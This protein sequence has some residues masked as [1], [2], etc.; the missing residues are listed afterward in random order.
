[1]NL[2]PPAFASTLAVIIFTFVFAF[3]SAA[4]AA[5]QEILLWPNGTPAPVVPN[6]PPE[7]TEIGADGLSR[8]WHVSRPRLWIHHPPHGTVPSGTGI[9]VVPG[10]GFGRLADEHEGA[11]ACT[12]LAGQG[13]TAFQLAYRTPTRDLPSPHTG[14]VQDLHQALLAIRQ[15]ASQ[16]S[17]QATHLGVLGFSAGAQ[18]ALVAASQKPTFDAAPGMS[19]SPDFLMLLYP[20]NIWDPKTRSLRPEIQPEH[21]RIPVFI[22]QAGD[23]TA[24]DPRGSAALYLECLRLGSPTELHLYETGG[25]GFGFKPDPRPGAPRLWPAAASVWLQHHGYS[26]R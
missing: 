15:R 8:R 4:P 17:I 19:A 12:W 11:N 25:H 14:P 26:R 2:P 21:L 5:P 23:D 22:A 10:G 20:Y 9:V 3:T 16:G 13:I 7:K 1:M 18:V 6:Q 24:S